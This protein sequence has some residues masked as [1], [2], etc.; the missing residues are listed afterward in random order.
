MIIHEELTMLFL[1]AI[2][3]ICSAVKFSSA[4]SYK[5]VRQ[6]IESACVS[7]DSASTSA[8]LPNHR[9]W[10]ARWGIFQV[11]VTLFEGTPW[12]DEKLDPAYTSERPDKISSV[13][14]TFDTMYSRYK[15][16]GSQVVS[17]TTLIIAPTL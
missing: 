6:L 10:S 9:V 14:D 13:S 15:I 7:R 8:N 1:C 5:R 2:G 17:E 3:I 11:G 12:N 4:R 16:D